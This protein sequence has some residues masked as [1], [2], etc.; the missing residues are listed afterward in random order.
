[1]RPLVNI[2]KSAIRPESVIASV[3][4]PNVGGIV[5]FIGTVR[6]SSDGIK[7]TRMELEAAVDMARKDLKRIATEARRRFNVSGISVVH[8][9]GKLKVGDIIVVVAVS[10]PHRAEAFR[11]CKFVIDELKKTTP[12]WKKEFSGRKGRWVE[13]V[14]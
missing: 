13:G 2:T 14:R 7:V 1:M 9:I 5:S 8:R 3:R 6:N 12:I 4:G 11:A 10:A